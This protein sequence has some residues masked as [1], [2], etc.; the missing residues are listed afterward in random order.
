MYR[1]FNLT[2]LANFEELERIDKNTAQ[3]DYDYHKQQVTKKL[4]I[5]RV[6][7]EA[8]IAR[9]NGDQIKIDAD[10]IQQNIFPNY[11]KYDVFISHSHLS[12]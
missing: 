2:D 9:R 7:R 5:S 10:Q 11:N 12:V 3:A 4:S 8:I 1:A 6:L